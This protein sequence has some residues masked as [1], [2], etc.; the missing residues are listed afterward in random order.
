VNAGVRASVLALGLAAGLA[1]VA[2][3]RRAPAIRRIRDSFRTSSSPGAA[4][5]ETVFEHLLGSFYDLVAGDVVRALDGIRA[6][7][8]L[9]VGPGPGGLALRLAARHPTAELT[10][11][12]VDPAMT[13]RAGAR[14]AAARLGSRVSFRVGNVAAMP[15]DDASFDLVVSTFSAHHWADARGGF[16]EIARVVRP[17]GRVL[18]YDLPDGW[19]RLETGAPPLAAAGDV[20]PGALVT[21]VRWPGPIGLVRRLEAVRGA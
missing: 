20:L 21:V 4:A 17:G 5:Y 7:R 12:D 10:G 3:Q 16:S 19:G 11:L 15:Y 2:L 14:A 1:V 6:P 18:V 9:E 13:A 8:V